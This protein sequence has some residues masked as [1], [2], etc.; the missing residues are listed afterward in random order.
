MNIINVS[1]C[2]VPY[3]VAN[4][5]PLTKPQKTIVMS[6]AGIAERPF[7]QE[8]ILW[9]KE[10]LDEYFTGPYVISPHE[11]KGGCRGKDNYIRTHFILI[12]YDDGTSIREVTDRLNKLPDSPL[13]YINHSSNSRP[14]FQKIHLV[15]PVDEPFEGHDEHSLLVDWL[16]LTFPGSDRSVIS[17]CS[18]GII[19][20]NL[21]AGAT[22]MGGK[23]PL[24]KSNIINQTRKQRA[25]LI[26]ATVT[27]VNKGRTFFVKPDQFVQMEN[28]QGEWKNLGDLINIA[29]TKPRI[30]CPVCGHNGALRSGNGRELTHNAT[31]TLNKDGLPIVYCSSCESRG[32]G[33]GG[34]G[35]YNFDPDAGW[36]VVSPQIVERFKDYFFLESKLSRV[37]LNADA[38]PYSASVGFASERAIDLPSDMKSRFL[39][40][41]A[42][43]A[44][45]GRTFR[46]NQIGSIEVDRPDYEW[47]G[48][49]IYTRIPA[50]RSKVKD[51]AFVDKWLEAL[52][53]KYAGFIKEWL[54]LYVYTNYSRLP[55]LI[56]HGQLRGT[57]KTTFAEVVG[58]L[59]HPLY[60]RGT[61]DDVYTEYNAAK[62]L[63]IDE[64]NTDGKTLY[65]LLKLVGGNDELSV[66]IKYGP[67]YMVR[68]NLNV[69][70]T[71][72]Q[73]KPI[74]V[75]SG[76]LTQNP[77]NNQF[78][79]HEFLHSLTSVDRDI[80]Q[81]LMDR[82]GHYSRTELKQV[83]DSIQGSSKAQQHRYGIPVPITDAQQR[84][85]NLGVTSIE[86][87]AEEIWQALV[88]ETEGNASVFTWD[89]IQINYLENAADEWY[90]KPASLR[91]MVKDL[92]LRNNYNSILTHLIKTRRL[93]DST[94][95][96][97]SQRLGY[98]LL[99]V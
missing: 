32:H 63:H 47:S 24:T 20:G 80:Q 85:F 9:T 61:G 75:E 86:R 58:K 70:I 1:N 73:L 23:T 97:C 10:Q 2:M 46:F 78:F 18:K 95:R 49:E 28:E 81:K 3:L 45:P 84:L 36:D 67:K 15:M 8:R 43:N 56:L 33:S 31:V 41:L 42:Q 83:F 11:M 87:E 90:L 72:N 93:S 96:T 5:G 44:V 57:G 34:S 27:P 38:E 21:D 69:I 71:T 4:T 92:E 13:Y 62:L 51:N 40:D 68:N 65:N 26:A 79:V 52:F 30:L 91:K 14:E 12:D 19:R 64:Q 35:V 94:V 77:S 39:T 50:I 22:I 76:E 60:T 6:K 54:A 89:S 59:F 7:I 17:D 74:H 88:S 25:E 66:N 16:K 98:K 55:V 53:Q 29:E 99:G 48:H 37:F 82:I